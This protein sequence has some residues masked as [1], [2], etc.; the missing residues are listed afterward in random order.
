MQDW[1]P[2][3]WLN[4]TGHEKMFFNNFNLCRAPVICP[5]MQMAKGQNEPLR[6]WGS[7]EVF[8]CS[9]VSFC[10][11]SSYPYWDAKWNTWGHSEQQQ[12][13]T[14]RSYKEIGG[15]C[16][17]TNVLIIIS[18]CWILHNTW[19]RA[20]EKEVNKLGSLCTLIGDLLLLNL[21]RTGQGEGV[22]VLSWA[23]SRC[24]FAD[25]C[26]ETGNRGVKLRLYLV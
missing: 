25:Q 11:G 18:A 26:W 10:P 21:H 24:L 7:T 2:L 19:E 14:L 22:V 13:M 23:G 20:T 8:D 1:F 6:T 9:V 16:S 4:C 3:D 12:N 17:M 5:L 15:V